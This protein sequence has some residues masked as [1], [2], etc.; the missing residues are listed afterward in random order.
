MERTRLEDE[1]PEAGIVVDHASVVHDAGDIARKSRD[2]LK[3]YGLALALSGL[4][5]GI[6]GALPVPVGTTIY[7]LPIVAVVLS[8]WLGGRG[9]GL[10]A[11]II[12]V[13]GVWYWFLPPVNTLDVAAGYQLPFA[14][15]IGLCLLLTEF[16]GGRRRTE[17][18]LRASEERF[19]TLMEFS[20]DVYW[21]T[22]AE[23]RFTRQEFS[24]R[25]AD[26]PAR[27]SE[28]GKTRWEVPYLEPDED[29]WRKHRATMDA[30]EPFRDFELA[31]PTAGGGKRYVSVSGMPVFDEAGRFVGY[32]GVGRHITERKRVE[33]ELR[34]RQEL[35]D[36]AQKAARAVAFD[37]YIGARESENRWSPDLEAMYG[38]EPGT[39]DGTYQGWKK[40]VHPDDWPAVKLAIKR[41]HESGDIEAEYRVIHKDGSVHWLRAKG[42]MF[43]DSQAQPE[44]MVG[45]MID[46]T[47]RRQA[48]EEL[49]ASEARFRTFVDRAT[50]AFFLMD[51]QIR[52]V[53][54]NRQA[55]DSLGWSREEL[56]GMHPREF[57]V[58]LDEPSIQRLAQRSRAGEI[59]T[60]ETRHRRKDG[61]IFPV[62]VRSGTFEQGGKLFYLA[63]ARDISE[64]KHAEESLRQ[65]EAYLTEA[66]RLSHT[67]S[68]AFDVASNRYVYTS[69]EIDRIFGF[70]P[71]GEKPTREV[72]FERIH[73]EDRS[74]WKRNLEKSL[75]EKVDTTDQYRIV[76]PDG[77]SGIFTRSGIRW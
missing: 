39:F 57:D 43:F 9:P 27:S 53:D 59:I 10:F 4:A 22:D 64:R 26:A 6:R 66:Q 71:Q 3:R 40:L 14:I 28:I 5:L 49:R 63:L 41:A 19:R 8:G 74:S 13:T 68:W 25:L 52:V 21:E 30:H 37:W 46:V 70:D 11:S 65:S 17:H 33:V 44:R 69:E 29:A 56:I 50:D 23:H 60:F 73:P 54:V 7:Q 67:G 75:R 36:L 35:L 12:C 34:S 2:L 31:R 77:R 58:A 38:L 47:D 62:E 15:F 42:R 20:F 55:C 16:S 18:A 45:F 24:E 32:R 48:E 72:I 61:T 1:R 76:L 51:E